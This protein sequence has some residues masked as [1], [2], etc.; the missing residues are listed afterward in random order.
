MGQHNT[1][2]MQT[3]KKIKALELWIQ[4]LEW[5]FDKGGRFK[6]AN[7][8][9][10]LPTRHSISWPDKSVDCRATEYKLSML[11]FATTPLAIHSF[12]HV[13]HLE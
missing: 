10:A 12:K 3:I 6:S 7:G 8:L 4:L 5:G 9:T 13:S 11:T 2:Q 1:D